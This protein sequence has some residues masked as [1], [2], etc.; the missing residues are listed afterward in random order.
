VPLR[1][2]GAVAGLFESWLAQHFPDS[3]SKVLNQIRSMR[4][5]KLYESTWGE[6]M[7]GS[8][9]LAD[10][11]QT[12]FEVAKRKAGFP[13]H[14]PKLSCDSFRVPGETQMTLF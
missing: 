2:P 6:R 10:Q 12:L 8:G 9:A 11:L 14:G 13:E 4:G 5:G 1:L 7:M 3:K